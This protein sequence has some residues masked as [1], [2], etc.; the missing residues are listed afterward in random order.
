MTDGLHDG[1][2]AA[3]WLAGAI[4]GFLPLV[5]VLAAVAGLAST[6]TP[7]GAVHYRARAWFYKHRRTQ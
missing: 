7:G 5:L 2:N 3:L 4:V 6:L 1:L